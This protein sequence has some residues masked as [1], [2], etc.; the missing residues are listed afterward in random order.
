M[1]EDLIKK[2]VILMISI[3]FLTTSFSSVYA[4]INLESIPFNKLLYESINIETEISYPN[5]K[6][7]ENRDEY[8]KYFDKY[9]TS[10]KSTIINGEEWDII[11]PDDFP[12]IKSAVSHAGIFARYRIFV[13]SGIYKENIVIYYSSIVLHGE[14]KNTTIIEGLGSK[15]E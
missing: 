11:V 4:G 2:L 15:D 13:R 6:N 10:K 9:L 5:Y 12:D 8:N 14:D 1:Q 7:K 3:L